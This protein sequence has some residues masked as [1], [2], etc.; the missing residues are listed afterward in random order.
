MATVYCATEETTKR[1]VIRMN[2]ETEFKTKRNTII[3]TCLVQET[4]RKNKNRK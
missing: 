2:K 4:V 1:K 3:V